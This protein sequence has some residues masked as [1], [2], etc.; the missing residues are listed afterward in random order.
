MH[1]RPLSR[2]LHVKMAIS[3]VVK[4]RLPSS[5]FICC[6]HQLHGIVNVVKCLGSFR[7]FDSGNLFI[8]LSSD[9]DTSCAEGPVG[10]FLSVLDFGLS[11]FSIQ[12]GAY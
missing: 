2:M 12:H 6:S 11:F 10:E 8:K 3:E 1:I 9:R 5:P 7:T 4:Y